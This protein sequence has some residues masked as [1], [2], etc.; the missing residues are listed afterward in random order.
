MQNLSQLAAND[1]LEMFL[2]LPEV[3]NVFLF[4]LGVYGMYQGIQVKTRMT[5]TFGLAL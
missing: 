2:I 1:R 5:R 4:V 3:T